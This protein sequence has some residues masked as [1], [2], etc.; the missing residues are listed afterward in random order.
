MLY[1]EEDDFALGRQVAPRLEEALGDRIAG[2]ALQLYIDRVGQRIALVCHHPEWEYHYIAV[3]HEMINAMALPGGYIYIT[4]GMLERLQTEAQLAAILAHETV[5]V[6]GRHTASQMSKQAAMSLASLGALAAG[7]G[8]GALLAQM[9]T[10]VMSLSYSRE[11]ETESDTAGL[12]YLVEAGYDPNGMVQIQEILM[13]EHTLRRELEFYSTHPHPETRLE[14]IKRRIK[15]RYSDNKPSR[16]EDLYQK[17]V[18][19]YLESHPKLP[20]S[21]RPDTKPHSGQSLGASRYDFELQR[22]MERQ[23]QLYH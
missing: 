7:S 1:S 16:T 22:Q 21:R 5:H 9:T 18:L 6:V 15:R 14:A 12:D 11:D 3:D 17:E 20:K 8:G 19:D 13:E 23:Q 10:Q 2:E 4:R